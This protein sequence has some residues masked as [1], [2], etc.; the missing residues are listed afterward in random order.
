MRTIKLPEENRLPSLKHCERKDY[1][2]K[3]L[4]IMNE[5]GLSD[6]T[7]EEVDA[8][9]SMFSNKLMEISDRY[10][11]QGMMDIMQGKIKR[12]EGV[13]L[14]RESDGKGGVIIRNIPDDCSLWLSFQIWLNELSKSLQKEL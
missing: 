7:K 12:L 8:L 4:P 10:V 3:Y 5:L 6:P 9:R 13:P 14:F 11:R 1:D 2:S